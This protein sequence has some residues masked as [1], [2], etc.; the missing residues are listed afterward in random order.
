MYIHIG[1]GGLKL[2]ACRYTCVPGQ[3]CSFRIIYYEQRD[4]EKVLHATDVFH[5][6]IRGQ[7]KNTIIDSI[8]AY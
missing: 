5:F 7:Y 8:V 3:K 2:L 6:I 1:S 4:N